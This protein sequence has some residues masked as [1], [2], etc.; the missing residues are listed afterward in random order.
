[1]KAAATTTAMLAASLTPA[2][3][4]ALCGIPVNRAFTPAHTGF[5][6]PTLAVL[7]SQRLINSVKDGLAGA[8]PMAKHVITDRGRRV[9][10]AA[11]GMA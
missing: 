3:R 8:G 5:Q 2:Q 7:K 10:A 1:M 11:E 4:R 9:R 6:W